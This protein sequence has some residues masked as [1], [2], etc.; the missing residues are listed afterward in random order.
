M[1]WYNHVWHHRNLRPRLEHA[2][3]SWALFWIEASQKQNRKR[4]LRTLPLQ[5]QIHCRMIELSLHIIIH[6]STTRLY[7][8][9]L[10]CQ[11]GFIISWLRFIHCTECLTDLT[12]QSCTLTLHS[13]AE[14]SEGS[15]KADSIMGTESSKG[16]QHRQ[17]EKKKNTTNRL[18]FFNKRSAWTEEAICGRRALTFAQQQAD[19]TRKRGCVPEESTPQ[20]QLLLTALLISLLPLPPRGK[21]SPATPLNPSSSVR[22]SCTSLWATSC[23]DS[24]TP[25]L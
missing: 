8:A 24:T 3:S 25:Q 7:I 9:S 23:S 2:T 15:G 12:P 13:H 14:S 21:G 19:L 4:A 10:R 20:W 11:N 5:V 17:E 16:H 1:T 6:R 22:L 18:S